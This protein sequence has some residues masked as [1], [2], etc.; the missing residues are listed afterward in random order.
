[1][2]RQSNELYRKTAALAAAVIVT[3][4]L[5]NLALSMGMKE[6]GETVSVS[7][8]PYLHALLNPWVI[9][10]VC[11]LAVW[12]FSNLSLL[13]WADLSYVLPVTSTA[14]V[15]AAVL[16]HFLLGE[17]VSTRRWLGILLIMTGATVVG[18]TRPRT[19]PEHEQDL[20]HGDDE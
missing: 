14:Y 6:V 15:L 1:M 10:G 17:P 13:S 3:N 7:L 5:G 20:P 12:L 19:T 18:L 11:L 9:G 2:V 8:L 16:G 4:V